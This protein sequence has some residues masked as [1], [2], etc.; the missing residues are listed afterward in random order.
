MNRL[1]CWA[2]GHRW[3][4]IRCDESRAI[5]FIHL[6]WLATADADCDR[7]NAQWRDFDKGPGHGLGWL[8]PAPDKEKCGVQA[9][10]LGE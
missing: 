8:K 10:L 4:I 2:F 5:W 1:I 7:C 9:S 3:R 6:H